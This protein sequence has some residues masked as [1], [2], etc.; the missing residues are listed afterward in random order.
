MEVDEVTY[1]NSEFRIQKT[2]FRIQDSEYRIQ[3]LEG[4]RRKDQ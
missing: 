4:G 2:G 1:D 3:K